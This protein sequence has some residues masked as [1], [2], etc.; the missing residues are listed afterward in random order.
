MSG[1]SKTSLIDKLGIKSGFGM[2]I[3]NAPENYFEMLGELPYKAA[4]IKK[5]SENKKIDFIH[6]FIREKKFLEENFPVY[7]RHLSYTGFLWISWPK[8]SSNV[9]TDVNENIIREIGLRKG[10]VDV[11]VCAVDEVWSGLK[12][13]YR[14]KDRK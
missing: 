4:V 14:I 11:K 13:V 6:S 2:Y 7:K 12:F 5:I 10:L 3:I 1:Y 8:V 9:R